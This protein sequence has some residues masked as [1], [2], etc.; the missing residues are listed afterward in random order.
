LKD[1]IVA[2]FIPDAR[3]CSSYPLHNTGPGY[4]MRLCF[5]PG[6]IEDIIV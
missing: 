3:L 5:P 1:G 2:Q 6:L 4:K